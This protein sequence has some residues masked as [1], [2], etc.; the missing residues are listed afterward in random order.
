MPHVTH[1]RSMDSY[2]VREINNRHAGRTS[3][4]PKR[5]VGKVEQDY[6]RRIVLKERD[7]A[8][9]ANIGLIS[10]TTRYALDHGYDV[11]L[12]GIMHAQR[13]DTMLRDLERD[14]LGS[15]AFYYFDVS[16]AETLRRHDTRP[17]AAEFGVHEM[18]RWYHERNLLSFTTERLVTE[19]HTLDHTVNRILDAVFDQHIITPDR[20]TTT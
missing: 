16:F 12:Q 1:V 8:G 6:L 19:T 14:H 18:R 7:V 10:L 3:R 20:E 5:P 11:V 2:A 9:G 15:T 13:Y 17:Q 4:T